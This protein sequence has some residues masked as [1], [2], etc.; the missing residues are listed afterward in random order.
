MKNQNLK[1]LNKIE[2][3]ETIGGGLLSWI[4]S[5]FGTGSAPVNSVEPVLKPSGYVTETWNVPIGR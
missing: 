2:L 4:A 1:K 3:Q 5:C